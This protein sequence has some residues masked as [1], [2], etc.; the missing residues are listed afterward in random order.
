M[1]KWEAEAAKAVV[2]IVHGAMEHHGRYT[3]LADMWTA[4]GYHVVMGDLPGHG[5][6]SRQRG[7]IN[8]FEE[9]IHTVRKWIREAGHYHLPIFLLGHSMGG[10]IIIRLLQEIELRVQ[11][12]ILSSPCLGVLA[13]PSMPLKAAAKVLN[14]LAPKM[15]FSSRLTAEMATRNRDIRD[16]MENDSL[17]LQ[18]VSVRWFIEL[19]KAVS[20][21]HERILTF[22]DI[23]LLIMQACK[24][25]LVDRM[26]VRK[27]FNEVDSSDKAYKEWKE[28]YHELFN[29]YE[30]EQIFTFAKAFTEVHVVKGV[31]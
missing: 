7:H 31:K 15:K 11:G 21:A 14:M 26:Q 13:E 18:K 3:A 22:P 1:W 25:K 19:K 23:P 20:I 17:L 4:A 5:T 8:S 29:E 6:S 24:D 30:R 12:I 16:A 9:Y 2:V 27:W 28:C 10:L